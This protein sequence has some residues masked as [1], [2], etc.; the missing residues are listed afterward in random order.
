[1]TTPVAGKVVMREEDVV[2]GRGREVIFQIKSDT[3]RE[4]WTGRKKRQK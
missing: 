4:M 1:M 3:R 2:R